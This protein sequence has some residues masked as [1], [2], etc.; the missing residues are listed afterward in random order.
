[1]YL[2][3]KADIVASLPR[4]FTYGAN[5]EDVLK[6]PVFDGTK[7]QLLEVLITFLAYRYH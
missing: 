5:L 1:M 6:M 2:F 3:H 7:L 4:Y